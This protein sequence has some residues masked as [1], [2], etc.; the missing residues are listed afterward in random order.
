K[1]DKPEPLA[2]YKTGEKWHFIDYSG[3]ELFPPKSI[4]K[5]LGYSEGLFRVI[6]LVDGKEK[7]Y[8]IDMKGET[9]IIPDCD[10]AWDFSEGRSA[11]INYIDI[12][13]Y[14]NK[15]GFIDKSGKQIVPII[16]KDAIS[17]SEGKAY[18]MSSDKRGYIDKDGN[19]LFYLDD[20]VVGY[21]FSEGY[22]YI[23][24]KEYKIGYIDSTGKQIIGFRFDEAGN[25]HGGLA[26]ANSYNK[27]GYINVKGAFVI[28][29]KFDY[30]SDFSYGRAFVGYMDKKYNITWGMIDTN[31]NLLIDYKFSKTRDFSDSLA[32]VK[33]GRT[34]GY[35]GIDGSFAIE[36]V[37][38]YSDSFVSGLAYAVIANDNKY[39]FINKKGEFVI[40]IEKPQEI[41]DLRTMRTDK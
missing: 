20:G 27:Y 36:P 21:T 15:F 25:F 22:A 6:S 26:F 4:H 5:V 19:F 24:N 9:A 1:D 8:F 14:N 38:S 28:E 10:M 3:K 7:Y 11:T 34:W 23:S 35:I 29:P 13:K 40:S 31:G 12:K 32:A 33:I 37:Y 16:Y 41:I 30:T 2:A 39:G 18:I 17:F